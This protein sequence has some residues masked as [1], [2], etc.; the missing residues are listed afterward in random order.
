M[1][2]IWLAPA[3]VGVLGAALV[4]LAGLRIMRRAEELR[5]SIARLGEL[6]TPLEGLAGDLRTAGATLDELRRR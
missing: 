6:R 4:A 2:A 5:L 1:S 3:S